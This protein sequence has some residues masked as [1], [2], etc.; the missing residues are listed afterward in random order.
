MKNNPSKFKPTLFIGI[1]WADS[2]HD[3]YVIDQKGIGTYQQ[4]EHSVDAIDEWVAEKLKQA[5][6]RPI[7]ILLEQSRGALVHSLM[8]RENVILYPINP[9]QFARYRESY[10]NANCKDDK[11]DAKL[12][13]RMLYERISTLKPWQPDNEETRLL[14]RLCRTRRQ[15]VD[16]RTRLTLKLISNLK[17]Y[18]PL[19]LQ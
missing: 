14:A 4:I 3:V 18:F 7:A 1:D 10:S 9:K 19:V 16:E 11:V 5:D 6:G 17:A 12:L 2:K 13:A 15:L 8:F